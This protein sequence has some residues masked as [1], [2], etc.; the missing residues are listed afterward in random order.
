MFDLSFTSSI[1]YQYIEKHIFTFY[2]LHVS[3]VMILALSFIWVFGVIALLFKEY[4]FIKIKFLQY[5][6]YNR[7]YYGVCSSTDNAWFFRMQCKKFQ[8]FF[9]LLYHY[10]F[11]TCPPTMK[12]C[13]ALVLYGCNISN[14]KQ[15]FF[16]LKYK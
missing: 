3:F 16:F 9:L 5:A 4:L 11:F 6:K 7:F 8:F 14:S 15:F 1:I 12:Y 10:L 13:A 2:R